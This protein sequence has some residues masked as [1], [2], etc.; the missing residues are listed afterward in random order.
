MTVH[1]SNAKSI[2]AEIVR[3]NEFK[4]IVYG[5]AL[6]PDK[7]D[8]QGDVVSKEDIE[9]T[10]HNFLINMQSQMY[11]KPSLIGLQHQVFKDIG[12]VVESYIDPID[13]SWVLGTKITNDDVWGKVMSG[14]ITG[15]SIGGAGERVPMEN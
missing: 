5:R 15:Y 11:D 14:E 4:K 7:E 12:Y 3:K 1:A 8:S 10:A 9:L 6:V 2:F 13:G